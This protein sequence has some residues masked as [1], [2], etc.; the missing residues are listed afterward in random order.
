MDEVERLSRGFWRP[1][2]GSVYPLL[3]EMAK[4]GVL[5]RGADGRYTLTAG[6][7][8]GRGWGPGK[9][10]PR[11]VDEALTEIR[12]LVSYLEDLKRGRASEF[13]QGLPALKDVAD[14]L[15]RLA[16]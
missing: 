14:R 16:E 8:P 12:G 5:K 7:V 6:A 2:P 15:A 11:N 3:D 10:G 9:F 13:E 4:E 1:S